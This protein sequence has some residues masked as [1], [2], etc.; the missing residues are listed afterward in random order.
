MLSGSRVFGLSRCI[1][2]ASIPNHI[3]LDGL[4]TFI[5]ILIAAAPS[6]AGLFGYHA[7]PGFSEQATQIAMD[8]ITLAGA[9]FAI[10]GRL[11]ANTPGWFA[12]S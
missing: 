4:K 2:M 1:L 11:V 7:M 10:Y 9:A 5:G 6:I 3:M 8:M 12:R